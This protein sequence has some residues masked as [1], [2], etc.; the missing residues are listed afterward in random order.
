M[1]RLVSLARL[2]SA[3]PVMLAR[4]PV[5]PAC[6]CFFAGGSGRGAKGLCR[7]FLQTLGMGRGPHSIAS[8]PSSIQTQPRSSC[9]PGKLCLGHAGHPMALAA[10]GR[11]RG[12]WWRRMEAGGDRDAAAR[13]FPSSRPWT[14]CWGATPAGTASG[15]EVWGKR[16]S[17]N[18]SAPPAPFRRRRALACG[19][20]GADDALGLRRK[21]DRSC[22]GDRLCHFKEARRHSHPSLSDEPQQWEAGGAGL[23]GHTSIPFNPRGVCWSPAVP[24]YAGASSQAAG[25]AACPGRSGVGGAEQRSLRD[26]CE[27]L[28]ALGQSYSVASQ[29]WAGDRE[30]PARSRGQY[31]PPFPPSIFLRLPHVLGRGCE[32]RPRGWGEVLGE[33]SHILAFWII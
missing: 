30:Q 33:S 20:D 17:C 6:A 1:G 29:A 3:L 25:R 12:S 24:P 31:M 16:G 2:P 9:T 23:G 21:A 28:V 8:G 5:H 15:A 19:D 18:L 26:I 10:V 13:R 4:L 11:G 14:R 27:Q 22:H 7:G 32:C